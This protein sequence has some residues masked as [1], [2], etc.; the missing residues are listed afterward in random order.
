MDSNWEDKFENF[1]ILSKWEKSH[2]NKNGL[3][4]R[5]CNLRE[6][7]QR[8]NQLNCKKRK[9]NISGHNG[10]S[11]DKNAWH[12]Q[13]ETYPEKLNMSQEYLTV[14]ELKQ[15]INEELILL[16]DEINDL[17]NLLREFVEVDVKIKFHIDN[18]EQIHQ[19]LTK[20]VN[21]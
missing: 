15:R 2:I 11:F 6:T 9:D 19:Q 17:K 7:T 21:K 20:V 16:H 12:F 4:N 5:E 10:I 3:D 8:E 18:L 13:Q 14:E 1:E